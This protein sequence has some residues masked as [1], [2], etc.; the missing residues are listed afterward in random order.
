MF[1]TD[2]LLARLQNGE[3]VDQIAQE[4]TEA[5]NK[6][7]ASYEEREAKRKEKEAA[8]KAQ[9]EGKLRAAEIILGGLMDYFKA[10][11]NEKLVKV[12][13]DISAK[14]FA[15]TL[16]QTSATIDKL[17]DLKKLEFEIPTW[18]LFGL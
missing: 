9:E 13:D 8:A 4:M 14:E 12:F 16:D 11:G 6:A 3:T 5:L 15:D 18:G 7:K 17:G 10:A 2:T 1:D